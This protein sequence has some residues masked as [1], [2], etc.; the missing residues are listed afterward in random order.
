MTG[1][2]ETAAFAPYIHHVTTQQMQ[3]LVPQ[4]VDQELHDLQATDRSLKQPETEIPPCHSRAMA[5]RKCQLKWRSF[6]LFSGGSW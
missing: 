1:W 3:Q 2:S 6:H 4:Q 5:D